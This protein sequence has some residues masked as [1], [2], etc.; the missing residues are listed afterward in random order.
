MIDISPSVETALTKAKALTDVTRVVVFDA[1]CGVSASFITH[2]H[3]HP[4]VVAGYGMSTIDWDRMARNFPYDTPDACADA[5]T[6]YNFDISNADSVDAEY[7]KTNE[8][9]AKIMSI[10]PDAIDDVLESFSPATYT[11]KTPSHVFIDSETLHNVEFCFVGSFIDKYGT[12]KPV[13]V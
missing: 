6:I 11:L 10:H 5:G 7:L 2:D 1:S 9:E 13:D 12:K 8:C 3:P 4:I